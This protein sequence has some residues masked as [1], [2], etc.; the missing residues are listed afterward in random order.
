MQTRR[1]FMT[2]A[3]AAGAALS[4]PALA[5]TALG[6]SDKKLRILFL[7]G[8]GFIGPHIVNRALEHGHEVTLANRGNRKEL[9]PDLELLE[10]NRIPGEG[11]GLS[12]IESAVKDGRRWDAVIDT[13]NVHRW[14]DDSAGLLK[15]AA[16]RYLFVSSL[17]VYADASAGRVEGDPVGTMPDDVADGI[18]RLPY[19]MTYFGPVKARCEAAAEK[20]FG[21]K[22]LTV[23][24]GLIVGPRDFSHRFTYWPLR[25]REGGEVL[26]P[27][28]PEHP[29]MFIDVR[30]VAA[31]IVGG[32]ER[33]LGGVY[34]VNGPVGGGMTIG[35]LLGACKQ[36][37]GSDA[38]FTWVETEFLAERGINPWQQM[39]VWIPPVGEYA[40]FHKTSVEKAVAAGLTTRPLDATIRETL[41]WY[42]GWA[43][44]VRES[45]DWIRQPGVNAPGVS[46]EQEVRVLQEWAEREG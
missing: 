21:D 2:T 27:G 10:I 12:A 1:E 19:D 23:R 39:P 28:A 45:R 22:A 29:V 4:V 17:S 41:E 40:G 32:I 14:V 8:T 25:V 18:D 34:N 38:E 3:A 44:E 6:A 7:G 42:D 46:S 5:R 30:D 16:D 26:A 43:E 24:P 35:A 15:E 20:H 33:G 9:F 37:T 36:T 13:A 11:A 31:F